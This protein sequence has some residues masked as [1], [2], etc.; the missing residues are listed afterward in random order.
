M[1]RRDE[2]EFLEEM[3]TGFGLVIEAAA[4]VSLFLLFPLAI[5]AAILWGMA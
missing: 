4:F 2:D 1:S 5:A 3:A